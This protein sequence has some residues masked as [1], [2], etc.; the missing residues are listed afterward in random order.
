MQIPQSL[1]LVTADCLRAD[2]VGFLGF[3]RPTTPFLDSLARASL[4][5]SR[6]FVAGSPTYYSLPALL[7]SRY[8]LAHGRDVI[9]IAPEEASLATALHRAGWATA[10]FAAGNPYL[11]AR[12]GFDQGFGLFQDFLGDAQPVESASAPGLRTAMN[13]ALARAS[14]TLGPLGRVYDELYFRYCQSIAA[15][16]R[17]SLEKLRRFPSAE[18]LVN[19]AQHWL[20]SLAGQPFFLWLHFMDCHAP[21]YPTED[22]LALMG[23][24]G[25]TAARARYLNSYWNRSDIGPGRLAR[26]REEIIAL[27]DAGVRWIDQQVSRLVASL[28]QLGLWDNCC[29]AFTADHGEEF[30]DHGGRF[31]LPSR[32]SEEVIHVPLLIRL[33]QA[34][35]T[36][37]RTAPVSHLDLAPTLLE[38]VGV[39]APP[40]FRGQ[41]LLNKSPTDSC[42]IIESVGSCT[43]PMHGS[44]RLGPRLLVVREPRYKL[45]FRFDQGSEDLYDLEADPRESAPVPRTAEPAVRR[46]LLKKAQAHVQK[47]VAACNPML[48]LRAK[49]REVQL[50]L[51]TPLSS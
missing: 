41:S 51:A 43:N 37:L 20:A 47:G 7:A 46:R 17:E 33:P 38:C 4:V 50:D 6:A 16:P 40:E 48:R 35:E 28:R 26:H 34:S 32:L 42:A 49:L 19:F 13:Q 25:V 12:F 10:A 18:V 5:F 27:Y 36:G 15:S 9:G 23:N 22:G 2:H 30:L 14:R 1:L 29:L 31:H 3:Q 45:V 11:S 8:P 39:T 24:G 44:S 21:Y